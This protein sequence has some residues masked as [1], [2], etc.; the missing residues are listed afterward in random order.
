ML[1]KNNLDQTLPRAPLKLETGS[2]RQETASNYCIL[3]LIVDGI[4]DEAIASV[5]TLYVPLLF[6]PSTS[7]LFPLFNLNRTCY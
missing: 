3:N 6:I 5:R 1:A 2:R 7:E 4:D